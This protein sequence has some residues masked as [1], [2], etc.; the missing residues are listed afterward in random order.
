MLH[1]C[2]IAFHRYNH[3]SL[4]PMRAYG[5]A[6]LK[7]DLRKLITMAATERQ[8]LLF[9]D[10]DVKLECFLEYLNNLLTIGTVP[11]LFA[12]D[13]KDAL[14]AAIRTFAKADGA[15][16][17]SLWNY[18]IS[19]AKENIHLILAM[20]PS[21]DLLRN[22]CRSFPGLVSCT[23][24][25][26]FQ[27]WP[28]SALSAVANV[29][30]QHEELPQEH[31]SALQEQVVR[32]HASVTT[33]Y[34]PEFERKFGRSTFSTPKNYMDFLKTYKGMLKA[35]RYG[36]DQLSSRLEGGLQKMNSVRLG[37]GYPGCA[38]GFG[39]PCIPAGACC[40]GSRALIA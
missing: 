6:D 12:D 32:V 36:I 5:E 15:R 3:F 39:R 10:A 14:I 29:L 38:L 17:D 9:S 2:I 8:C 33:V 22:R 24:I 18:A 27:P 25:D 20:S 16:E 40:I 7:E 37:G 31:C 34:A 1:L 11:A 30:L 35:K 23:S 28:V 26:W 13:Q 4:T 21:G 19:R